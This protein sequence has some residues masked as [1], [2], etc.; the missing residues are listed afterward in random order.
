[1]SVLTCKNI[2]QV[3]FAGL[4]VVTSR[5]PCR[6]AAAV[7]ASGVQNGLIAICRI[8]SFDSGFSLTTLICGP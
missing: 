3:V 2:V 1:M 5:L 7:D 6:L 8:G 4:P